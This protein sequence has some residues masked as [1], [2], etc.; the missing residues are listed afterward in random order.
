MIVAKRPASGF[1]VSRNIRVARGQRECLVKASER[2]RKG[3]A[4]NTRR[5]PLQ[6]S[7]SAHAICFESSA[8][9]LRFKWR[10]RDGSTIEFSPTKGWTSDDSAKT[11]WLSKLD[12]PPST[13]P[14]IPPSVLS[15]LQQEC[16]LIDFDI[17]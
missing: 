13:T 16:Q 4:K 14:V 9:N 5:Q 10:H 2:H 15:W 1:S 6:F 12:H 11:E 3:T 8:M 7:A 17:A